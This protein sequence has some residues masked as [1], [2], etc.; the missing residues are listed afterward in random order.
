M[1]AIVLQ[2]AVYLLISTADLV[3]CGISYTGT[4]QALEIRNEGK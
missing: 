1:F 2:S 4:P 3:S